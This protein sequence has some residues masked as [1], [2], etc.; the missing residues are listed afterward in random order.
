MTRTS[1]SGLM[2]MPLSTKTG[3]GGPRTEFWDR[4]EFLCGWGAALI[5]ICTTFP[6]NKIMFRQMVHGVR[7]E[8][9]IHQLR[10]E[11]LSNLYKGLLP[12]L[13]SKTASVS[14]M[15]GSYS[16]YRSFLDHEAH[17]I[18]PKPVMR[19]SIAAFLSGSTEAILCP[20]ER[21]QMLLQSRELGARFQNTFQAF[22]GLS[23]S[24]CVREYYRGL[25]AIL[26]RNGPSNILFFAVKENCHNLFTTPDNFTLN[27]VEHFVTGESLACDSR[28]FPFILAHDLNECLFSPSF[29]VFFWRLL[30]L[31]LAHGFS[32]TQPDEHELTTT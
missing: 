30:S 6:I 18:L 25:S 7:A 5:N 20:F 32:V 31:D 13:L 1:G 29:R 3:T 21:I 28:A 16:S 15:F 10:S 4:R 19:L 23:G 8:R 26:L 17:H 27:L 24:G 22:K 9:A 11:G 14:L 12:P 2:A